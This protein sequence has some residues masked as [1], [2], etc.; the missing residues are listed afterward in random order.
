M[1]SY[2]SLDLKYSYHFRNRSYGVEYFNQLQYKDCVH[3]TAESQVVNQDDEEHNPYA[4]YQV[5]FNNSAQ[6]TYQE[7]RRH[8]LSYFAAEGMRNILIRPDTPFAAISAMELID[9]LS[10]LV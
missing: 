4:E 10:L 9:I 3:A 2:Q 7:K 6:N 1:Y 8:K 5:W